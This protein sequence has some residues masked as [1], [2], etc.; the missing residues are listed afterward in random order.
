[1]SRRI[2]R[3]KVKI[4]EARIPYGVPYREDLP[5]RVTGVLTVLFLIFNEGYLSSE[6]GRTGVVRGRPH[7]R[8]DPADPAG[9]GPAAGRRRGRRAPGAHAPDRRAPGRA[10][11][12]RT[13]SSSPSRSRTAPPGTVS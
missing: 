2:T 4:K 8:G 13:A 5:A 6:P 1:M 11:C 10:G 7:R 12:R 9:P 3:A